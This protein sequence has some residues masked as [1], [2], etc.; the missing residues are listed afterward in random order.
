[1]REEKMFLVGLGLINACCFNLVK[2]VL[3]VGKWLT[4]ACFCTL[5][6]EVLIVWLGVTWDCC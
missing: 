1:M 3:L 5:E 6:G 4:K 2:N